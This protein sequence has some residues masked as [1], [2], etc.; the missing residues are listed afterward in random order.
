MTQCVRGHR[1]GVAG[2]YNRSTYRDE[3]ARA[4]ALWADHLLAVVE[5]R[6]SN[7]VSLKAS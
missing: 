6:E 3:K 4:L 2:V 7:I 5:G 1:A